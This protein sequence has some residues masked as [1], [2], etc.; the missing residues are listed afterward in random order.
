M[1]VVI[2]SLCLPVL[3]DFPINLCYLYVRKF[4]KAAFYLEKINHWR[5]LSF[6]AESR[7][8]DPNVLNP[9]PV[10]LSNKWAGLASCLRLEKL[11]DIFLYFHKGFVTILLI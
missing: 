1:L 4:K 3:A 9:L 10:L 11:G 5:K 2:S 7:E 6:L 8:L